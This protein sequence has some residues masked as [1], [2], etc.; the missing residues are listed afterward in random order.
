MASASST[1]TPNDNDVHMPKE[2]RMTSSP[3]PI[4]PN[5]G[6]GSDIEAP[7]D[8]TL[9]GLAQDCSYFFPILEVPYS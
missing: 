3:E 4:A 6:S 9:R 2:H 8:P 1:P 7:E 5:N